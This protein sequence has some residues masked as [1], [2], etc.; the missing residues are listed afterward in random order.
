MITRFNE[1]FQRDMIQEWTEEK[2]DLMN[3]AGL[4][5][6][7]LPTIIAEI[8]RLQT[9]LPVDMQNELSDIWIVGSYALR[10]ATPK[11]DLDIFI[12]FPKQE[13]TDKWVKAYNYA[14]LWELHEEIKRSMWT[15]GVHIAMTPCRVFEPKIVIAYSVVQNVF[16]GKQSGEVKLGHFVWDGKEYL[17]E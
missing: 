9:F 17:Y 15:L 4:E 8:K 7:E 1:K 14:D 12:V 11:S 10:T 16:I 3:H 6:L 5:D 2:S 13:L